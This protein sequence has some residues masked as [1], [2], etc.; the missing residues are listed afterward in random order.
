MSYTFTLTGTSSILSADIFPP[1][2]FLD[3]G[4]YNIGLLSFQSYNSIPNIIENVNNKFHYGDKVIS[5]PTWNYEVEGI[6]DYLKRHMQSPNSI[7]MKGNVNTF[8]VEFKC[9]QPVNFNKEHSIG[10]LLGFTRHKVLEANVTHKSDEIVK[11]HGVNTIA[12]NCNVAAG[13][14]RNGKPGHTI[15][16]FSP[17]VPPGYKLVHEPTPVIYFP[18]IGERIDNITL[19]LT[20][21]DNNLV[22]FREKWVLIFKDIKVVTLELNQ[23]V[24]IVYPAEC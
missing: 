24:F 5:I 6:A 9:T 16:E 13:S 15:Y 17:T 12:I 18:V 20:D 19:T 14:Y 8:K 1:I 4:D 3:G 2:S 23:P 7:K 11:I 22:N 10:P 21:Q